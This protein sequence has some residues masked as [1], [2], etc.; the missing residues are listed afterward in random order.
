MQS[1]NR[2][3]GLDIL[4]V[5][6][7]SFIILLHTGALKNCLSINLDPICRFAVPCFFMITGFFYHS[8]VNAKRDVSQI[9]KVIIL[10]L[11]ANAVLILLNVIDCLLSGKSVVDWLLS[12][13]SIKKMIRLFLFNNGI[14]DG[15]FGS[16]Y[17]WYLNELYVLVIAYIFRKLGIFKVL[18]YLTPVLLICG[19]V[20]ECF[21]QQLFGVNFSAEASYCYY[22]NF[23]TVGI[24][25]FCIGN[26]LNRFDLEKIKKHKFALLIVSVILLCVSFV[27]FRVELHFSL[28]TNGEFFIVTPLYSISIFLF[29]YSAFADKK[30]NKLFGFIALVGERYVVWIYLFHFP[31]IAL[32]RVLFSYFGLPDINLFVLSFLT[33]LLSFLVSIG[34]DGIIRGFKHRR[35]V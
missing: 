6:C 15:R 21:S 14:I 4:K 2:I 32:I 22:R 29:F 26:L 9:K 19:F 28:C 18:Y 3:Y 17:I 5:F 33:L 30:P 13:V 12:C 27:E 31:M 23:L 10:I 11:I 7:I 25:Y 16:D 24:P 20:I 1:R 35:C 8:T 34:V